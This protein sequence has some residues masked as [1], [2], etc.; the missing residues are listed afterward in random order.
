MSNYPSDCSIHNLERSNFI[1]ATLTEKRVNQRPKYETMGLA[2]HLRRH[3]AKL[4]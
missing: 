3:I 2:S 4:N 1:G